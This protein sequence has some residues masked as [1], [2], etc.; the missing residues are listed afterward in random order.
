MPTTKR[1]RLLVSTFILLLT[2]SVAFPENPA[3]LDYHVRFTKDPATYRPGELIQFELSYSSKSGERYQGTWSTPNPNFG[4]VTL[5]L[6]P[7]GGTPKDAFV[8]LSKLYSAGGQGGSFLSGVGLVS[9]APVVQRGEL[10]GWFRF[11]KPGR[12][13]LRVTSMEVSRVKRTDEGGGFE[14]LTLES[15]AIAFTIEAPD[16]AWETQELANILQDLR[17]DPRTAYQA[18]TR[19][20]A[21]DT[22]ASAREIASLYLSG[23]EPFP[24]EEALRHSRQL[25]TIIPEL[26]KALID[27]ARTAPS[28]MVHLLAELKTRELLGDGPEPHRAEVQERNFAHYNAQLLA[29]LPQR[30]G[31]QRAA[32]LY[33]IWLSTEWA[34]NATA[35]QSVSLD[36][37]RNEVLASASELS[38]NRQLQFLASA[39]G[40]MP[41]DAMLPLVR[42]MAPNNPEAFKKLCESAPEE[43]VRLAVSQVQDPKQNVPPFE[44]LYLPESPQPNLDDFLRHRLK[45][46]DATPLSAALI[47]RLGSTGLHDT[48]VEFL[49]KPEPNQNLGCDSRSYLLGYLYRV[50]P[51]DAKKRFTTA[52]AAQAF[53]V[54]H[55]E[56]AT[57]RFLDAARDNLGSPDSSASGYAALFLSFHGPAS[58]LEPIQARLDKLH[59]S[60]SHTPQAFE[61]LEM[62]LAGA[63]M[64]SGNWKLTT[65]EI[66]TLRAS[67]TTD[68]C[69]AI[70]D[71]K[72]SLGL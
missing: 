58:S 43:C 10:T 40:K 25:A 47:L 3:D 31:P 18:C 33:D 70:A 36:R 52:C 9:V 7:Q 23:A 32:A 60:T 35:D 71:G 11:V 13:S 61:E 54:F 53:R 48:V 65:S 49:D 63:L 4:N 55:N 44:I 56:A 12:Y 8:D 14:P 64:Q 30:G 38:S 46:G 2:S 26:E 42:L 69:R 29:T 59:Y 24:Y 68:G 28:G 67:C 16:S 19:L 66:A 62:L 39:W 72:M 6:E 41:S 15:N 50:A 20:A 27:P 5:H 1:L 37:L 57:D 21:L 17:S 45:S 34:P 22:P 51:K